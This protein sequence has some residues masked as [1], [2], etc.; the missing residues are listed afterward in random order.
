MNI[1]RGLWIGLNSLVTFFLMPLIG[2][3]IGGGSFWPLQNMDSITSVLA[4]PARAAYLLVAICRAAL[5]GG[6]ASQLPRRNPQLTMNSGSIHWRNIALE[7]VLVLG[8][9]CDHRAILVLGDSPFLRWCGVILFV[10]GVGL[11]LWAN[12]TY[13]R[14]AARVKADPSDHILVVEGPFRWLRYP[15]NL[16][17][18]VFSLG[19]AL[20]FRSWIG[21]GAVVFMLNF[22]IMRMNEVEKDSSRKFGI[23]WTAYSRNSWR[24][25]PYIY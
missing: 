24:L 12:F 7:T 20:V 9:F 10:L 21:L 14:V 13:A 6:L 2:W 4:E 16:G 18:L 23:Q 19:A 3:W 1:R 8:P 11:Q 17:M 25:V 15:D 5:I 22:M